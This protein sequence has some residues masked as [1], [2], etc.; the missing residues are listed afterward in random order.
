MVHLS[1]RDEDITYIQLD[2]SEKGFIVSDHVGTINSIGFTSGKLTKQYVGHSK[3]VFYTKL[4]LVNNLLVSCS[5]DNSVQIQ[6]V[7]HP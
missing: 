3:E 1:Q 4:D 2:Q 5:W 7:E 6:E